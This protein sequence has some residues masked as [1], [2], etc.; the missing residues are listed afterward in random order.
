MLQANYKILLTEPFIFMLIKLSTRLL[1][2]YIFSIKYFYKSLLFTSFSRSKMK[3]VNLT[4]YL[5][6]GVLHVLLDSNQSMCNQ[7]R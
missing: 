7:Q 1:Q 4:K 2:I 6:A 3:C 5:K